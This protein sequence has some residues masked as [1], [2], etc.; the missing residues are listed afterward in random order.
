[1]FSAQSFLVSIIAVVLMGIIAYVER[2]FTSKQMISR[3]MH[4][5]YNDP[6]RHELIRGLPFLRHTGLLS[7][8]FI[9]SPAIGFMTVYSGQWSLGDAWTMFLVSAVITVVLHA[10]WSKMTDVQ[11]H[12]LGPGLTFTLSGIGHV[13]YMT[14]TLAVILLFYF[15][16]SGI[17]PASSL[18]VSLLLTLHIFLANAL[19]GKM[20]SGHYDAPSMGFSGLL[21]AIVW[22]VHIIRF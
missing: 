8:L 11:E 19:V 12:I 2:N 17:T 13:L 20:K 21:I 1:M 10:A 6:K 9:L 7:D 14:V 22:M 4:K 18:V 16:T 3:G 15:K 5:H